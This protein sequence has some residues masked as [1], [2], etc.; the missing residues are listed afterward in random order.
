METWVYQKEEGSYN[1]IIGKGDHQATIRTMG[2]NYVTFYIYNGAWIQN[3]FT[4]PS[5]WIGKWHHLAAVVDG[6]DMR[7][8]CDSVELACPNKKA[9]T[10][11]IRESDEPFGVVFE[12]EHMGSRD[13]KNKYA[14]V[15]IYSKA[16]SEDEI[17]QQMAADLGEGA[18]AVQE[19][20][21]SVVMWL[22]Y[23]KAQTEVIDIDRGYYDY[24]ANVG[25]E[26]MAGKYYAYGGC[27]GDTINSGNFC[28]NGLVGPDRSVQDE[29]YEVKYVYQ[30][31]W[32]EAD[33]IDLMNHKVSVFNESS[34][35][36]L[37]A[38]EVSYELLEDGKVID[39]G[40]VSDAS[41]KAGHEIAY[42]QFAVPAEIENIAEPVP[43]AK[44]TAVADGDVLKLSGEKFE[45]TFNQATGLIETYKYDG[46]VVMTKGP[47]P[48][49]WRGL[50]D[51]D[52]REVSGSMWERANQGMTVENLKLT[53]A[54]DGASYYMEVERNLPNSSNSKRILNYTV[55][56]TG[57]IK[58][59]SKL[60]PAAD[61]PQLL[62]FGAEIILPR[63]Y[64]KLIWYGNGPQ[65]TLYDRKSGGRI[66]LF[67]STV[68]DSFYPY[69]QPQASGN[70]TDVR[71]MAVED[72]E[73]PVGLMV[74]SDTNMEASALH[75]K[76]T[77]YKGV[78]RTYELPRDDT[79]LS[80]D[81]GSKGTGVATC[82]PRTLEEY[83]LLNDGRDYSYTY[84]IVPYLT[85]ED[86]DLAAISKQWRDVESFDED[87]FN[88]KAAA[89]VEEK[90][91]ELEILQSY[92]QKK[93][94]EEARKAFERLND[95]Q[96]ALVTNLDILERA[97]AEIERLIGSKV[98]ITDKSAAARKTEITGTATIF[99]DE[100]S[101][102]GYS[103]DG[104]FPVPDEDGSVNTALSGKNQFTMEIWVN[105][106]NL[107]SGNGF[108]MK[109]DHQVSVKLANNGL[110]YCIYDTG[111]KVAEVSCDQAGF[112]ANEWNHV[113]ATYDGSTMCLYANGKEVATK[114]ISTTVNSIDCPL[115]IGKNYEAGQ[116]GKQLQGRMAAA[117]VYSRALTADEI[118]ARYDADLGNGTS[119][120]TPASAEVVCWYDADD[121]RVD[122]ILNIDKI[123]EAEKEAAE[124]AENAKTDA[125]TAKAETDSAI[126]AK[127]RVEEATKAAEEARKQA[128]EIL[129]NAQAE[130]EKRL[131]DAR[132]MQEQI[133]TLLNNSVFQTAKVKIK[134]V[135]PQKKK[136]KVIWKKTEGAEGYVIQYAF[137]ASFRGKKSVIVKNGPTTSKMIKGL[138]SK[139]TCFVRVRAY[140]TAARERGSF[141][142]KTTCPYSG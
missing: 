84:T 45:L 14:Y 37:S 31:Y 87:K 132:Q 66:G 46:N 83:Q 44:I 106:A 81:Y 9:I 18:Y 108:I 47:V 139:K 95:A 38:Y 15:R 5:D 101:P 93:D 75:F 28:Q 2:K 116:E 131:A 113:A 78:K 79:I 1:T 10:G 52:A 27:W 21:E 97:E 141:C 80:A 51:N 16:L 53:L 39:S 133:Q 3:D 13:G 4:M 136:V 91:G 19:N 69:G 40:V 54:E 137:N 117:R 48:N 56:S 65:E 120:I 35:M 64:E 11:E 99:K 85:S 24:Y 104:G 55:Y 58:I 67:E 70:K 124:A 22:D 135:T 123:V 68:S 6:T 76:T 41:A 26:S 134:S 23:S 122:T 73:N 42:E 90:I 71:F 92:D 138:K 82:G 30:K 112:K 7:V 43:A 32:F 62:R 17:K 49:Y 109:G 125:E 103:F 114:K 12:S 59:Y 61:A 102:F 128:E 115:G 126:A 72:P 34:L 29:L 50:F 107:N 74:V 121:Y 63:G 20:D 111:W 77:D 25:N 8:Y 142:R 119:E 88:Q 60:N 105:P 118:K 140:K 33:E 94:V 89:E 86:E 110:E 36:D 57:E 129:K 96:K 130:A 98:Y 127:K 100:S